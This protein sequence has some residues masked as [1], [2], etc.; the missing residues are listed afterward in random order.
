[1]FIVIAFFILTQPL[2]HHPEEVIE[3]LYLL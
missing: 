1:M 2:F 3:A